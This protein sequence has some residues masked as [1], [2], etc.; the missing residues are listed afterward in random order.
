MRPLILIVPLAFASLVAGC[1]GGG[2][3]VPREQLDGR[4]I[5]ATPRGRLPTEPYSAEDQPGAVS[6]ESSAPVIRGPKTGEARSRDDVALSPA[7]TRA[8]DRAV[9]PLAEPFDPSNAPSTTAPSMS[10]LASA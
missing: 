6:Y 5:M 7:A 3:P 9:P 10:T 2:N 4:P 8:L 1:G